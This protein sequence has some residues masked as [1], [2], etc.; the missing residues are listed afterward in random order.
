MDETG[1]S[2]GH[3]LDLATNSRRKPFLLVF[4]FGAQ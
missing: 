1:P 3:L 4:D 2:E